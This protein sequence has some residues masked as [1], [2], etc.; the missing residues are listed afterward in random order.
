MNSVL[1]SILK[2]YYLNEQYSINLVNLLINQNRVYNK[3]I[4]YIFNS[5][6]AL[7]KG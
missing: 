6:L 1:D 7:P 4:L 2:E 3:C 5:S